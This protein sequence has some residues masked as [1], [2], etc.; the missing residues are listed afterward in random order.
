MGSSNEGRDSQRMARIIRNFT[1]LKPFTAVVKL[2]CTGLCLARVLW[3]RNYLNNTWEVTFTSALKTFTLSRI[4][5]SQDSCGPI[6]YSLLANASY[7]EAS[8]QIKM[9][10]SWLLS[11]FSLKPGVFKLFLFLVSILWISLTVAHYGTNFSSLVF[12]I[13]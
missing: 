8:I 2:I 7:I 6:Q 13:I 9:S 12:K 4:K 10:Q 3:Y 1:T 5:Y 11:V